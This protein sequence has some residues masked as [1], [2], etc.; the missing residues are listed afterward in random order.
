[1]DVNDFTMEKGYCE[2]RI[3]KLT[4][5]LRCNF[6]VLMDSDG[7]EVRGEELVFGVVYN[8][9]QRITYSKEIGIHR[10]LPGFARAIGTNLDDLTKSKRRRDCVLTF[11]PLE[12]IF[13]EELFEGDRNLGPADFMPL[14]SEYQAEIIS[15]IIKAR[16]SKSPNYR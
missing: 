15:E 9:E 8:N 5:G 12:S 3:V 16:G 11:V 1:M 4:L 7:K 10:T 2:E 6:P 14:P 13:P